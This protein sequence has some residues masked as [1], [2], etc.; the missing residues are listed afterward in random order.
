MALRLGSKSGGDD[1]EVQHEINVTPFIDVILVLLIIFMVAAPLATVDI[2]VNLPASTAPEQPR[3]EKPVFL[4]I[5]P[6]LAIA[7]GDTAVARETLPTALDAATNG[8]NDQTI[9]VRADKSVSYGELM[10]IMNVLL[11]A[12]YLKLALVGLETPAEKK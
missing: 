4:T 12:G 3:P 10:A 2:G 11:D 9:F 6:D 7:V 1:L 5:Q 8:R